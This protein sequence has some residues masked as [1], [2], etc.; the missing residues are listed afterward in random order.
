MVAIDQVL[1]QQNQDSDDESLTEHL[2]KVDELGNG[3]WFKLSKDDGE[4]RCKLAAALPKLNK[5]IFVNH[6]GI[7]VHECC[8]VEFAKMLQSGRICLIDNGAVFDR[9]LKAVVQNLRKPG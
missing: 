1:T 2:S 6:A 4:V 9:A 7:K 5:Y 3:S 8:R